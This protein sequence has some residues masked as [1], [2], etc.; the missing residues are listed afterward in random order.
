MKR[1]W[2]TGIL[3]LAVSL[4]VCAFSGCKDT[5]NSSSQDSSASQDSGESS[6]DP[7]ELVDTQLTLEVDAEFQLRTTDGVSYDTYTS[8]NTDVCEVTANGKVRAKSKGT[9]NVSVVTPDG[10]LV[11][12]VTVTEKASTETQAVYFVELSAAKLVKVGDAIQITAKVQ[13]NGENTDE[14]VT[15]SVSNEAVTYTTNG[16]EINVTGAVKGTCVINAA[17]GGF[18]TSVTVK[19]Y[20]D[21]CILASPE[22]TFAEGLVSWEANENAVGYRI[23]VNGGESWEETKETSYTMDGYCNPLDVA[24][25]A[26]ADENSEYVD[27]QYALNTYS[28]TSTQMQSATNGVSSM[29]ATGAE[30]AITPTDSVLLYIYGNDNALLANGGDVA[31]FVDTAVVFD[32]KGVEG[33]KI[34]FVSESADGAKAISEF[35]VGETYQTVGYLLNAYGEQCYIIADGA[36]TLT[37]VSLQ[38]NPQDFVYSSVYLNVLAAMEEGEEELAYIKDNVKYLAPAERALFEERASEEVKTTLADVQIF[39]ENIALGDMTFNS[40]YTASYTFYEKGNGFKVEVGANDGNADT[41]W[42]YFDTLLPETQPEAEKFIWNIYSDGTRNEFYFRTNDWVRKTLSTGW[43]QV[44]VTWEELQS[45]KIIFQSGAKDVTAT[46]ILGSIIA[47][48]KTVVGGVSF[49]DQTF[50]AADVHKNGL[51][52][53]DIV[54]E[55]KNLVQVVV[56][57]D[58]VGAMME[59]TALVPTEDPGYDYYIWNIWSETAGKIAVRNNSWDYCTYKNIVAGWNE[60]MITRTEMTQ[61][62]RFQLYISE[63]YFDGKP[64]TVTIKLGEVY[65]VQVGMQFINDRL[66]TEKLTIP[67]GYTASDATALDVNGE[68]IAVLELQV[69]NDGGN[70]LSLDNMIP[71]EDPGYEYYIWNVWA[72]Y[73]G[74]IIIRQKSDWTQKNISLKAGWNEVKITYSEMSMEMFRLLIQAKNFKDSEN[75][76]PATVTIKLGALRGVNSVMFLGEKITLSQLTVPN[77][78]TASET[79]ALAESGTEYNATITFVVDNANKGTLLDFTSFIPTELP[80]D[81]QYVWNIYVEKAGNMIVR[82]GGWNYQT[83]KTLNAGWNQ[84]VITRNELT[85]QGKF[86]LYFTEASF[87][88]APETITVILGNF[89]G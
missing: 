64:E 4:G 69:N 88:G 63:Q 21:S 27:S 68:T 36:V 34:T 47:V 42:I 52:A 73:D 37:N 60:F 35:T 26:R 7:I 49:L 2:I 51:T 39:G 87:D 83:T 54:E 16:N 5:E 84:V 38:R 81:E 29:T 85:A 86:E 76:V 48:E 22:L 19:I 75:A 28:V 53:T 11:C 78:Y 12:V 77:G 66:S 59:F 70:Q 30:Y 71:A 58:A 57:N 8:D 41:Q 50:S 40:A 56:D 23:T 65:G 15:W 1:K 67:G 61:N 17:I 6:V 74:N 46:Y 9:A 3:C 62:G 33:T 43:N 18:E 82:N 44:E 31:L 80:E 89:E 24:V 55:E 79:Y 72:E 25:V 32:V 10:T 14:N 20:D 45:G 13:R